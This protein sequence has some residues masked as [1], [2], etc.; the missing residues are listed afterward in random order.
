MLSSNPYVALMQ[1]IPT[2]VGEGINATG[3]T[4]VR[5]FSTVKPSGNST[6]GLQEIGA[7]TI[8][9]LDGDI[10]VSSDGGTTWRKFGS[11]DF[12]TITTAT[13]SIAAI[14]GLIYRLSFSNVN[15]TTAGDIYATLS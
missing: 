11:F 9:T 12:K 8:T 4:Q 13:V 14:A 2:K 1:G 3:T 5:G 10:Q 6:I 15:T 7:G